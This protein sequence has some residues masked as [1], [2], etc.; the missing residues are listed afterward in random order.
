MDGVGLMR[1]DGRQWDLSPGVCFV[2]SPGAQPH[3][4]QDPERRL[5]VYGMHFELV[6][7]DG[8]PLPIPHGLCPPPGHL[9]RDM[10]FFASLAQRCDGAWR[11]GDAIGARQSRLFLQ[12]M[13]LHVWDEV[14]HPAP[15]AVDLA[16]DGIVRAIQMEPGKRWS[17]ED[18]AGQ[19]HLSRAQFVRRFQ[20]ATGLSPTRFMVQ[21]RLERARQLI[22]ETDMT[23]GQI[24]SALGY[25]DV[26][27]FS[28]QYKQYAGY[29]PS[30]LRRR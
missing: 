28:R 18:L 2:F 15:S 11:R 3:G 17:V 10:A 20:A 29:A 8:Q 21:A 1:L 23:L 7:P 13:I 6:Q 14:I 30:S 26:Y 16:L 12:A 5:I 25:E 19:T 22:Q 4:T 9:I 27:F 24:A